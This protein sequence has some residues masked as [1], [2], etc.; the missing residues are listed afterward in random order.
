MDV[1]HLAAQDQSLY[2]LSWIFGNVG[3]VLQGSGPELL[4]VMFKVFNTVLLTAGVLILAYTVA[5]G[6]IATATDGEFLGKKMQSVWVPIRTLIGIL[7]L[8]PMKGG[9]CFI[10]VVVMW[11]I[12]QG[13]GAADSIWDS[14]VNYAYGGVNTGVDLSGND[15]SGNTPD[16]PDRVAAAADQISHQTVK[17]ISGMVIPGIIGSLYGNLTCLA[18][19]STYLPQYALPQL[20][21]IA[22]NSAATLSNPANLAGYGFGPV[23]DGAENPKDPITPRNFLCGKIEWPKPTD[24]SGRN[25][26]SQADI[27]VFNLKK[28]ALMKIIP[29]MQEIAQQTVT[30]LLSHC[31]KDDPTEPVPTNCPKP[32]TNG[33]P[34]KEEL[35]DILKN[36][37]GGVN[38]IQAGIDQ[39]NDYILSADTRS[40]PA[41]EHLAQDQ[42]KYGWIFAGAFYYDISKKIHSQQQQQVTAA[43]SINISGPV[44]I[45]KS[46]WPNHGP[47]GMAPPSNIYSGI[48]I[49]H[50]LACDVTEELGGDCGIT[51]TPSYGD[52][53][54]PAQVVKGG[55][56]PSHL[57]DGSLGF[58]RTFMDDIS[59]QGLY[60]D[61]LFQI[62][63][64]GESIL[65]A[66]QV[67]FALYLA[68]ATALV[69]TSM[70]M[71]CLVS[72]GW[73]INFLLNWI[74]PIIMLIL[75]GLL[76]IGALMATYV[77]L[78]PYILFAFA[79]IG[80]MIA[81]I[82]TMVAA[83]IVALGIMLP[84]GQH[85]MMGKAEP[86]LMLV[87]N[88]FLRPA[89]IIFGL[90]SGMLLARV[91]V[92]FINCGFATAVGGAVSGGAGSTIS[93]ISGG[94]LGL[95][96]QLLFIAAYTGIII[97]ALNK[98]FSLIHLVPDKVMR[99]IGGHGFDH[100]ADPGE[101]LQATQSKLSGMAEASGAKQVI[102]SSG[103][104]G[105]SEA[106]RAADSHG[107]KETGKAVE[108]HDAAS[109]PNSKLAAADKESQTPK[110]SAPPAEDSSS[111][112][113]LGG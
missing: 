106:K 89:L 103:G 10:Q 81:A 44:D 70:N 85:E 92:F 86:A 99:W 33:M 45:N 74:T 101:A 113:P 46:N 39:Y 102:G 13:I 51:N 35:I 84:G 82:E 110:P 95:L 83:P 5:M 41:N 15:Y 2:Y 78:I 71:T 53:S 108:A 43:T 49:F 109:D 37:Y 12:I 29:V 36:Y 52:G 18:V 91:T 58:L 61:P 80:W 69:F 87:A 111:G 107:Q 20:T 4:A 65:I 26:Q 1:F 64:F 38:F 60:D 32:G 21:P 57:Q 104:M 6:A 72:I 98:A 50:D 59:G 100:L 23:I 56:L 31:T 93:G 16:A 9:Y 34:T 105:Q 40:F 96:E 73:G 54:D 55:A 66:V 27:A 90:V 94:R 75:G 3:R 7:A 67:F 112:P 68:L 14:V 17:S 24:T 22:Y 76:G 48:K 30:T 19:Y 88:V 25:V 11:C 62:Q 8:V 42:K 47:A 63:G 79:A 97:A 77:P 28:Q